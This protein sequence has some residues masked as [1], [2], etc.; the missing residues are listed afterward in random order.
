M[1]L[2]FFISVLALSLSTS[3]AWQ[4][5]TT[6]YVLVVGLLV[7]AGSYGAWQWLQRH[8]EWA[9][10]GHSHGDDHAHDTAAGHDDHDTPASPA[11]LVVSRS[12]DVRMNDQMRFTPS[13]IEVREGETIRFVV[14]NAGRTEHE[15]VLGSDEEIRTH[16]QAMQQGQAHHDEHSHGTGAAITVPAGQKGELVVRFDRATTLLMACLIPGHYEAGMRG[17]LQVSAPGAP[18]PAPAAKAAAH[19]HGTHKH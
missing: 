2:G 11:A 9:A 8:P 10:G 3:H 16:A 19:D 7:T 6:T 17:T 4:R 15:M 14:H 13:K 5:G 12:I 18:A 1:P